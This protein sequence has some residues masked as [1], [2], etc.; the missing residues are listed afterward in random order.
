MTSTNE[1]PENLFCAGTYK[2]ILDRIAQP[3]VENVEI[4]YSTTAVEVISFQEK[5]DKV[6]VTTSNKEHLIFDEVVVTAPLGWLKKNKK[7]FVPPLPKRLASAIDNIG[8]GNMTS[9]H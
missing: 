7:T 4:R 1:S 3:A 9:I 8:Y 6:R 5:G 2:K